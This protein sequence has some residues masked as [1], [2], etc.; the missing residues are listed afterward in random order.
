[1]KTYHSTFIV[2]WPILCPI[3]KPSNFYA[4][5]S[6]LDKPKSKQPVFLL[7]PQRHVTNSLI[8]NGSRLLSANSVTID[9]KAYKQSFPVVLF[10]IQN[11]LFQGGSIKLLCPNYCFHEILSVSIQKKATELF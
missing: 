3:I 7:R 2:S 5:G 10:I 9:V 4:V 6:A 11:L 1:M 8:T